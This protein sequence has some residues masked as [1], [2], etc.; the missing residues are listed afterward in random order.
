MVTKI[1]II[2]T[3]RHSKIL[4]KLCKK[5]DG[6]YLDYLFS[7]NKK[8]IKGS[9]V[10]NLYEDILQS[11]VIFICVPPNLNLDIILKLIKLNYKNYIVC[12]KPVLTSKNQLIKFNKI[13]S[14]IKK[15]IFV[16][17]HFEYTKLASLMKHELKNKLNG[18]FKFA[19]FHVSHGSA[20]LK[21]W[22]NE[23]RLKSKLGPIENTAIH[24]LHYFVLY[25]FCQSCSKSSACRAISYLKCFILVNN[26]GF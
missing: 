5:I 3:G 15:K 23:W 16:N 20:W 6:V 18:K 22:N 24:Y 8:K 10:T 9:K 17:F 13:S 21:R 7:R 14:K 4:Q 19:E 2:G 11:N 25:G 12:E 26:V 1:S